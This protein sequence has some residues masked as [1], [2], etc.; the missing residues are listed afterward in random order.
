MTAAFENIAIAS[1]AFKRDP[2]DTYARLR[3]TKPLCA[4][5]LPNGDRAWLLTRYD[6][7]AAL[8]KDGRFA[9]DRTNAQTPAQ[10]A[11]HR[12]VPSIFAPLMRNMLDRDDPDHA[13][14]RKLVHIAFTPRRVEMMEEQTARISAYLISDLVYRSDFDLM[15]A[16]AMPLP[17]AV[18][19]ALLGV[20]LNDHKRF[21]RYSQTLIRNTM[22]PLSVFLSLPNMIGFVRYLRSLIALK[23]R[24]PA[25]DLITALVQAEDE[26]G[27]LDADELVGMIALLLTAGHETTTNLIA[28][29]MLA[30]LQNPQECDRIR[31]DANCHDSAV[32]ELLRFGGFV[33]MSTFRFARE[34]I[35]LLGETIPKGDIVLGGI[36]SANRDESRFAEPNRLDI[37][38]TPNKH[39]TFGQG[40]HYCV[41]AA[42]ARLEGRIAIR[43]LITH[44]PNLRL[45]QPVETL[46]WRPGLVLR[47]LEALPV[48]Q[49]PVST[50]RSA[51]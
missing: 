45:K 30:L 46:R 18:I 3:A 29:G 26:G 19:C 10:L 36:A 16:Y 31:N 37:G 1:R 48:T 21:A 32:E 41:G 20:P 11:K 25:D 5:M 28:N 34:D 44:L 9:K 4:V 24:S 42:L 12:R 27:H 33:D 38:R 22:T 14:L 39:L 8:L 50:Q 23:R 17:V 43:D 51:S 7:V 47:G 49:S 2:F 40:G 13:R 35:T 6:D 15:K